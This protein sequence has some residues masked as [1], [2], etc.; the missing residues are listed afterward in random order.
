MRAGEEFLGGLFVDVVD[1]AVPNFLA[2]S[3]ASAVS[4]GSILNAGGKGCLCGAF[5][6]FREGSTAPAICGMPIS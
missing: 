2:S 1:V 3:S 5:L 4:T 6:F